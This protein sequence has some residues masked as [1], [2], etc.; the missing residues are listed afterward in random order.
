MG[1]ERVRISLKRGL[2]TDNK[3]AIG[4]GEMIIFIAMIL[5][6]GIAASVIIQTMNSLQQQAMQTAEQTVGEISSG[7]KITQISGY[8]NRSKITQLAIFVTPTAASRDI[9]L[10]YTYISLSDTNNQVVLTYNGSCFSRSV[11][12]G[13]F[14]TLNSSNL[15][16]TSYGV[17]VIRDVDNSCS[18][19]TPNINNDDLVVILINTS[20][21]FSGISKRTEVTGSVIPEKGISGLIGFTTPSA[22]VDTIIE[23]YP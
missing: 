5:V 16:A 14:G 9:D 10:T 13:L 3:A 2:L 15:T 20:K 23:L 18:S 8:N 22:Y 11:S 4:I 12:K 1:G 19:I 17:M 6:A 21:C 7:L